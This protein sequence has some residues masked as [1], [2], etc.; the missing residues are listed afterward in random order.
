MIFGYSETPQ[1]LRVFDR[2]EQVKYSKVRALRENTKFFSYKNDY[3][4]KFL[5]FNFC[6]F[7]K[8][9]LKNKFPHLWYHT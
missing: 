1:H 5:S 2:L 4:Y 7:A 8:I 3:N 6:V 9:F